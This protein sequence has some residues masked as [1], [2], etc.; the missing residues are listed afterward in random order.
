MW[1]LS[2]RFPNGMFYINM[3]P[4]SGTWLVVT[5]PSGAA[6][7]QAANLDK[8]PVLSG[9]LEKLNGGPSLLTMHGD[10]WKRWRTLFNPGFS[11]AYIMAL[12]PAVTQEVAVFNRLLRQRALE[13]KVFQLEDMTLKLTVD[14][15]GAATL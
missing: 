4:F 13:G 10:M 14:T 2:K 11:P 15:I 5:T 1:Q 7:V 12:A 6:Q 9:P 3:W 8:P